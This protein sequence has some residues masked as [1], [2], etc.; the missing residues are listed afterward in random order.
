MIRRSA[1]VT[2]G[3]MLEA[4]ERKLPNK[5]AL[6]WEDKSLTFGELAARARRL[7]S[8]L[9]G[10]GCRRQD[11]VGLLSINRIEQCEA[12]AASELA[13]FIT[14]TL[15]FRLSP[16]EM[17]FVLADSGARVLIFEDRFA[18]AIDQ[19][20]GQLPSVEVY[21]CI[22]QGPDWAERYEDFV[23]AGDADGPPFRAIE[24]DVAYLIYTSGTTGKPKGCML[25]QLEQYRVVASCSSD[26]G[27]GLPD[28]TLLAMPMFHVG[29]KVV[30]LATNLQGATGYLL[31]RYDPDL[32]L[33][34]LAKHRATVGHL[35]P[36]MIQM[37]LESPL[38][39]SVDTSSLRV[40]LYSASAM[41]TPVLRRA[42]QVFGKV[43]QQQYGLTEGA[44][45]SLHRESHDPD[46]DE[47]AQ[48]RL[49]SVGVPFPGV[50]V[51]IM[52]EDGQEAPRGEAGEIWMSGEG[53]A[54]GYW[55]NSLASLA[56]FVDGWM[57]TGDVGR[58]DEDGYLYLVDRKKDMI[59]SGGENIYSREVEEVIFGHPDVLEA[60]VIGVADPK[61]GEAVCAVVS[62]RGGSKVTEEELINY[63]SD[64]IASYKKPKKIIFMDSLPKFASGKIN[65]LDL[66]ARYAGG[67][68]IPDQL[69]SSAS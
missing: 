30:Q 1:P 14:T 15:N 29:G 56:T 62:L 25:G 23:A 38:I 52:G 46:G 27:I 41:P 37:L 50:Q 59:I 35:A 21:V 68:P 53:M 3:S 18:E 9:Q 22:G 20:R 51:R 49:R 32:Y 43:F 44:G 61:W 67:S 69:V 34:S 10:A 7:A 42:I 19:I 16:P 24:D 2:I 4:N 64:N 11:R 48:R 66:R 36:T 40:L 45:T 54:R 47:T 17:Q 28:R 8:A 57:R 65:K 31:T 33:K 63:C 5:P 6:V 58:L 55:N 13:G 26:L 60:A 12:Y 39:G